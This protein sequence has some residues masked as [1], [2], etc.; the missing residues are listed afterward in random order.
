MGIFDLVESLAGQAT[1]SGQAAGADH[2]NVASGFIEA[3]TQ[4]PEGIQG[5]LSALQN[6]GMAQHA[7][8]WSNGQPA[9]ATPEQV[10]QGLGGTGL[11]E[12]AAAKAG[13]SPQVAHAAI[14]VV[15]PMVI[16]HFAP[17]GQA[18]PQSS[19]GSMAQSLLGKLIG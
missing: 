11:I 15:L 2:A 12:A 10:Q 14:A 6:N 1:Q 9:T 5:V 13:V 8:A 4:H 18:A 17:N 3:L 16:Q 7:E 19:M